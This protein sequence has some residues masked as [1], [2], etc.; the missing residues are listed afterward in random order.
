MT[1][2]L[3]QFLLLFRFIK[4]E[5]GNRLTGGKKFYNIELTVPGGG[6]GC[7]AVDA[8]LN[9]KELAHCL[10]RQEKITLKI[11]AYER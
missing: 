2:F 9:L 4:T 5:W 3:V 6:Q 11:Y 8:N 10:S 1:M 7:D